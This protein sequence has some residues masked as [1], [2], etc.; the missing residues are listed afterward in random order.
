MMPAND[1]R[2][3]LL[4][5]GRPLIRLGGQEL[6]ES[7]PLKSQALLYYL[8][9]TGQPANRET[10]AALL[11][12][13]MPEAA[14]RA[15][16]RLALSRLRRV[17]GDCLIQERQTVAFDFEQGAWVDARAFAQTL[18]GGPTYSAAALRTA[19]NLYRGEFLAGF[20][21]PEAS[22]FETWV[23]TEREWFHQLMLAGLRDLLAIDRAAGQDADAINVVR[24][25]L[26]IAPWCE[27]AH[28]D[29]M[30]MLAR[31]G[32]RSAALAQYEICRRLL[33]AE[34]GVP[35]SAKTEQL[36]TLIAD[37]TIAGSDRRSID[38]AADLPAA[39][40]QLL[41][42]VDRRV[43]HAPDYP[44]PLLGRAEAIA[45]VQALLADPACRLLTLVGAGGVGK[46]RLALAAT[47]DVAGHYADGAYFIAFA[48][49]KPARPETSADL[50]ISAIGNALGYTFDAQQEPH[51]ILLSHL[52]DKE[53]LLICDNFE[54]LRPA[55]ALLEEIVL[56]A[57][58]V[59]LLV[60]SRE[61]L[62]ARHE[63]LYTVDGL[64]YA[65]AAIA[66]PACD[67][68]ATALFVHCAQRVRADFDPAAERDHVDQICR[69]LEGW[70]L[71]IE[72]A[73][74]WLQLLPCAAIAARLHDDVMLL[75]AAT[76]APDDRHRSMRAVLDASW[77][78]LSA[79]ERR[80]CGGVACFRGGFALSAAQAVVRAGLV[81]LGSL[82]DKSLLRRDADGRYRM[83]EQ[84]RQF[85]LAKLNEQPGDVSTI[86]RR[87]TAYYAALAAAQQTAA[88]SVPDAACVA[89][90]DRELENLRLALEH[91]LGD[92]DVARVAPL[93][94]SLLPYF[95]YKGWNREIVTTME[96]ACAMTGVPLAVQARWQRWWADAL[97]QMGELHACT[98]RIEQLLRLVG[99]PL[100]VNAWQGVWFATREFSRQIL[101]RLNLR[102]AARI[103]PSKQ[104]ILV[105]QA[106]A[107]ERYG[108]AG[109][110]LDAQ[111]EFLTG[112][113]NINDAESANAHE[114]LAAGYATVALMLANIAM[115]R[116]AAYYQGLA[117][118]AIERDTNVA[119]RAFA[120]EVIGL[121]F[122]I[123]GNWAAAH[124]IWD[125]GVALAERSA[126][127][128]FSLEIQMVNAIAF[129]IPGD[130]HGA[131][132]RAEW[133]LPRA[134]ELSDAVV[135]AWSLLAQAEFC[136]H[137]DDNPATRAL[138]LI[139]QAQALPASEVNK[140]EHFRIYANLAV[141][142]LR[143]GDTA[144]AAQE[145]ERALAI[146]DSM[147]LPANW[148][149]EGYANAPEVALA[150]AKLPDLAPAERRQTMQRAEH[151][152]AILK[153][154]ARAHCFARPRALIFAGILDSQK[155]KHKQAFNA[156]QKAAAVAGE[157]S[158][159]Y[160]TAR[161]HFE[162]GR[163]LAPQETW[164]GHDG[165]CYLEQARA[166]FAEIGAGYMLSR[167]EAHRSQ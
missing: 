61:R 67:Y 5:L 44:D 77:E 107:L 27:E 141:V 97:Y 144:R 117:L 127:R 149:F 138:P 81:Q 131:L 4:L 124:G 113:A 20:S 166:E 145:L 93:L 26:E 90:F 45:Q 21:T 32:Q 83:H 153:K 121:N 91:A 142:F 51:T 103:N 147:V 54:Q 47:A 70:P 68:P 155:G 75:D 160:D 3:E 110:F 58:S 159:R 55:V 164:D 74:N 22:D 86:D 28:Q 76:V 106:R 72:L 25:M 66:E 150:L 130:Y 50:V 31:S 114:F 104:A 6:A 101:H 65:P 37:G 92:N 60:T 10:L 146:L 98:D 82:V 125:E 133:V 84:V 111:T 49:M 73:A 1:N 17:V 112:V 18:H 78:L 154:F 120:M 39:T 7:P 85:A 129:G 162:I 29:L 99:K 96:H 46:T 151:A 163:H 63:W 53:L 15:N 119:H 143:S 80:V 42:P 167:I 100:P 108:Q 9:A 157:L 59:Q 43:R 95:R 56:T 137:V 62:G 140:S 109:Y 165:A 12:G 48:G 136:L 57:P 123:A 24:R 14:A 41:A 134:R 158:M 19:T 16:L 30:E 34:L 87:H 118:R 8:A 2:L 79:E 148:A 23:I 161:A 36:R 122:F 135:Q 115:Y 156:W 132:T 102:P 71:S 35:P 69:L 126:R 116:G 89:L 128:R 139:V 105:E 33:D 13:D 11:W 52:R 152:C 88:G 40:A 64:A 38:V 94:E